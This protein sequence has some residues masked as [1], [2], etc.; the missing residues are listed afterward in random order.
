MERNELPKRK[1]IRLNNFHYGA[2]YAYFITVCTKDRAKILS[3]ITVGDGA[4]DVPKTELTKCGE[5]VEKYILS[6][7][8]INNVCV[9][10]YVIMPN[11]FHMI[12]R[13]E[14]DSNDLENGTS[15]APSPTNKT[16]PH[17]VSTLKRFCNKEIGENIFQ[18]SFYDHVI[19]GREDYEEISRYIYEN[20]LNWKNDELY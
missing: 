1:P 7:N 18:R 8:K 16:I 17:I 9:D 15:R 12:I 20:P 4:L 10:R 5:I 11:H 19:R 3:K 14:G 13:I 2:G 6:T